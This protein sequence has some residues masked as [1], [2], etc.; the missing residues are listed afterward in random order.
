MTAANLQ[1]RVAYALELHQR[2]RLAEAE[3]TYRDVLEREPYNSDALHL[4]GVLLSQQGDAR[5]ALELIDQAI[6]IA[7]GNPV[8]LYNRGNTLSA[9]GRAEEAIRS[10]EEV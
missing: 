1:D 8:Q 2:G 3:R 7:P 9:F 10:Y 4:L 5:G 6:A